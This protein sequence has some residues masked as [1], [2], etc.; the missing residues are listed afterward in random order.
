VLTLCAATILL[1]GIHYHGLIWETN[2]FIPTFGF[3]LVA[4]SCAA[5]IAMALRPSSKTQQFFS[6]RI[7]RFFGKYSYGLYVFHYS[8]EV[9]L[10]GPT[11]LYVSSHLHSKALGVLAGACLVMAATIPIA[12]LSYHLYEAPFLSLKQYFSYNKKAAPSIPLQAI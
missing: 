1:A 8:L 10:D 11:R 4:I 12:L 2:F 3:T 7:L 6:N 9:M 5:L